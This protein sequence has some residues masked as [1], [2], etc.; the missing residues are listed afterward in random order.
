MPPARLSGLT[1][2]VAGAGAFGCTVA[3]ALARIG[4]R[5]LLVDPADE[6]DNASGVAAGMLAPA[7]E[8]L[9]DPP[10]AGRFGLLKR[11]RSLWPEFIGDDENGRSLLRRSGAA[12]VDRPG[13]T[14][15]RGAHAAAL[16]AMGA[17]I[18]P[19]SGPGGPGT[20]VSTSDDWLI[21]PHAA[22]ARFLKDLIGL[23]GR[24]VVARVAAFEAGR[25]RLTNGESFAAERLVIATGA[26]RSPLAP[27]LAA[28]TPIKGQILHFPAAAAGCGGPVIRCVGGYA[29]PGLAGLKVG[30]TMEVGLT[31]RRATESAVETLRETLRIGEL[32]GPS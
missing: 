9:L 17:T 2:A 12:W 18:A 4:A 27:E 26:E 3:L 30:A 6:A 23:G 31:D 15:M 14:P 22:L 11:A 29:A 5:V 28:L 7:F 10:M 16:A 24:R 19:Y 1:V 21:E 8:A 13:A 32:A 20:G 25:I